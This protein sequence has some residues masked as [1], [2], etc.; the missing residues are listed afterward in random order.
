MCTIVDWFY[1]I[2][3][4]FRDSTKKTDDKKNDSL[5]IWSEGETR[6]ETVA[7]TAALLS[8]HT[9]TVYISDTILRHRWIMTSD[10][11]VT[12]E[13][14]RSNSSSNNKQFWTGHQHFDFFF[15]KKNRCKWFWYILDF[16]WC[17][18][19]AVCF[20]FFF[21]PLF[22]F[23]VSPLHIWCCSLRCNE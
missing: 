19:F 4:F 20:F 2:I 1:S 16:E 12:N 15:S 3:I 10:D 13:R 6:I 7:K 8:A 23:V 18:R 5:F 11:N 9:Q 14:R 21:S 17:L 22:I